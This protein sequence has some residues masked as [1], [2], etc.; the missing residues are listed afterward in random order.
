MRYLGYSS[1]GYL[2]TCAITITLAFAQ[3]RYLAQLN[4]ST[5]AYLTFFF[6]TGL[7]LPLAM[8]AVYARRRLQ[9]LGKSN[10]LTTLACIPIA[11]YLLAFYLAVAPGVPD[12]NE[13]GPRAKS[14]KSVALWLLTIVPALLLFLF[15]NLALAYSIYTG[16]QMQQ[17]ARENPAF[18]SRR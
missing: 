12:S 18:P 1:L 16:Y 6:V 4:G 7:V 11:G 5:A 14:G 8:H 17:L 9:D 13:F 3:E 15:V 10:W 2:L